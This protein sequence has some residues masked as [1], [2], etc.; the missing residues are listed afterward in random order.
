MMHG[1]ATPPIQEFFV[2]SLNI[3]A[4]LCSA[5]LLFLTFYVLVSNTQQ[6]RHAIMS[7]LLGFLFLLIASFILLRIF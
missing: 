2:I 7:R 6:L 3:S 1:G 4:L 5:T